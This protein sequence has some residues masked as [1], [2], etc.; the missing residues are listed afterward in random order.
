MPKRSRTQIAGIADSGVS[1][2]IGAILLI[3]IV[4]AAVAIVGVFLFSLNT[5]QEIPS[6]NFMTGSDNSNR[7]YL[8][9]NGGDSLTKGCFS[10][11]VDGVMRNDYTISDGSNVWSLGTNL[12]LSGVSSSV[13]HNVAIIYNNTESGGV[14]F[15]DLP[16]PILLCR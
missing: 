2:V 1:E 6:I 16:H 12:I 7:L 8:F 10:V 4:I 14:S 11:I 13:P 9:H 3:S 5:P 15:S